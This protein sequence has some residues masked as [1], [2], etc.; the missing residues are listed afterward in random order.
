MRKIY[1]AL[2]SPRSMSRI[3]AQRRNASALRDE[4]SNLLKEARDVWT[5]DN[6]CCD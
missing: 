2:L 5:E 6:C 4:H 1:A 3:D